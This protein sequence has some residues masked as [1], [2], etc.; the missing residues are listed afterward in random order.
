MKLNSNHDSHDAESAQDTLILQGS[1]RN[2]EIVRNDD[3]TFTITDKIAGR[4]GTETIA[5]FD[6]I[7][8]AD[9]ELSMAE[10]LATPPI[11]STTTAE[12]DTLL[13][14]GE[15]AASQ[16]AKGWAEEVELESDDMET[17]D[18]IALAQGALNV[19]ADDNGAM[20]LGNSTELE[21]L[22][23]LGDSANY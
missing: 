6:R 9:G 14:L 2:Y 18:E 8:F 23:I 19:D 1:R 4:D 10:A 13:T 11:D 20:A 17:Q 12:A 16:S 22:A 7:E 21:S 5:G 3:T 15:S